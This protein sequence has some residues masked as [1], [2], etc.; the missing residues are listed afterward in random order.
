MKAKTGDYARKRQQEVE[1]GVGYHICVEL[2]FALK[3]TLGGHRK[4]TEQT[5]T[6]KGQDVSR[7]QN[8][9]E[10]IH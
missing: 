8:K 6:G 4:K 1:N 3:L 2:P 5:L 10:A 9:F 7:E